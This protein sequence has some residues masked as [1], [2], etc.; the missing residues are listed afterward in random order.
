MEA[1]IKDKNNLKA[2]GD[3]RHLKR[4]QC[5]SMQKWVRSYDDTLSICSEDI[6]V[7]TKQPS[8]TSEWCKFTE[9]KT[10][11]EHLP[12]QQQMRQEISTNWVNHFHSSRRT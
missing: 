7:F 6:K 3:E 1:K 11:V 2:R 5:N 10:E 4:G 8:F 9:Q 12:T